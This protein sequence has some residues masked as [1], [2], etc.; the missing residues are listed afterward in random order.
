MFRFLAADVISI[1]FYLEDQSVPV[2]NG[3][4]AMEEGTKATIK[5]ERPNPAESELEPPAGMGQR[6]SLAGRLRR[7][8]RIAS[9]QVPYSEPT[10]RPFC[11]SVL[12]L[13][14]AIWR[15][16]HQ[17]NGQSSAGLIWH[18]TLGQL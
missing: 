9:R 17:I 10:E 15:A 3:L 5:A 7:F 14:G 6:W 12:H 1:I 11:S 8:Q 16:F 18:P 4:T 2:H 13:R